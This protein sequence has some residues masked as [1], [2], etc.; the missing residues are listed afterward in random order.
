MLNN[1][2]YYCNIK[3]QNMYTLD[4]RTSISCNELELN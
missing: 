1:I 2:K 4:W 3:Y